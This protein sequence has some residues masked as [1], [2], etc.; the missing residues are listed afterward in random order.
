MARGTPSCFWCRVMQ[1]TTVRAARILT[2]WGQLGMSFRFSHGNGDDS[3]AGRFPLFLSP[4]GVYSL[5]SFF[6]SCSLW[7]RLCPLQ[8]YGP[9]E[10]WVSPLGGL[11]G[12]D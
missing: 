2:E 8:R 5:L 9:L 1:G 6:S 11:E 4:L 3:V 10:G 7:A 12:V